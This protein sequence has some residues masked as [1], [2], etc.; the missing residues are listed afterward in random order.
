MACARVYFRCPGNGQT[1]KLRTMNNMKDM[2]VCVANAAERPDAIRSRRIL[3]A[4]DDEGMRYLMS[5]V[6]AGAGFKVK[7]ASD[8]QKAWEASA[9]IAIVLRLASKEPSNVECD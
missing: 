9:R 3:A 4:D 8:G 6:L 2:N 1:T 7:A 5:T